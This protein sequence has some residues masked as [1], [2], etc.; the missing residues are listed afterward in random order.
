MNAKM[1]LESLFQKH[2]DLFACVCVGG[3]GG[4]GGFGGWVGG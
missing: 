2:N 4:G 3:G 1:N